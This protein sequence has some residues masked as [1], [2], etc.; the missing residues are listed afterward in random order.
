MRTR[1]LSG[2]LALVV[3]A[4]VPSVAGSRAAPSMSFSAKSLKGTWVWAFDG[5]LVRYRYA[6][7]GL[8]TF[9]GKGECVV[10]VMENSG[11]N[12]AYDHN[13][14]RCTYEVGKNGM[15]KID[16]ALD[17]EAGE[18]A[19]AVGPK[20]IRITSTDVGNTGS[21][22]LRRAALVA[23]EKL[24]G[25]WTFSMDGTIFG[26]KL[27]GAGVMT[28][29]GR[30]KC[31]QSLAYNYGTGAQEVT[32]DSCTYELAETGIG[33]ADI[34]Y[35]NGTGGD[36]YFLTANGMKDLFLL[37]TADGEVLYAHGVKS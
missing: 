37:T 18:V 22:V 25:R 10:T 29:D 34:A 14:S 12:G 6:Q 24:V 21:G 5:R 32:T 8:A 2:I 9:D 31:S 27:G 17:G 15:G 1:L 7:L 26:E 16:Y 35:S 30:G 11:V 19:I 33:F 28:F 20:D 36:S 13:S 4:A 3:L 23:P